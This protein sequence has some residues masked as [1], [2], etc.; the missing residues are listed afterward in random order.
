MP[1]QR[2]P[3]WTASAFGLTTICVCV[4]LAWNI[5]PEALSQTLSNT[6][7]DQV[8]AEELS[9]AIDVQ[10]QAAARLTR[11]ASFDESIRKLSEKAQKNDTVPVIVKVRAAFQPEG[12]LLDAAD[13]LAQRSL[14]AEAQDRLLAEMSY[15][16]SSLKK[17]TFLP[18][19]AMSVDSSGL[20]KLQSSTEALMVAGDPEMRLAAAESLPLVSALNAWAGGYTGLG[21]T[22]VV[23]DSGVDKNHSA[24][25]GKVVSE[26][27]F[28]TNDPAAGYSSLCPAGAES[29][30]DPGSGA[31]CTVLSGLGACSH[32]THTA[33]IAA[34]R[35]GVAKDA[36][37]ISI[38]VMSL[39]TDPEACRG[40][41]SCLLSRT[42]DVILALN[43]VYALRTSHEIAAVNI[44]LAIDGY[45][46]PC[47]LEFQP[48]KDAIDLLRTVNIATVIPSGN[49]F[50]KDALGY[51]ACI[52]SAV[53]VGAT[54]D[55]SGST[56]VDGV[57]EFSN[58]ASFLSLLAPG[59]AITSAVPGGVATGAG[60]SMAAAH[61]TGAWALLKQQ[62]AGATVDQVLTSLQ[63]HGV[64][65]TDPQ[66]S[67]T[68]RRI[69]IDAAM[70]INIPPSSWI[71]AYYNNRDLA[72]NPVVVRDDGG[73][74][75]DRNF[76]GISP[77]P[78]DRS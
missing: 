51:P 19:V 33:G 34:G 13:L 54:G 39:V 63:T 36:N 65:I 16:P 66:N 8:S 29:S 11:S 9:A 6:A 20:E 55:G 28:S 44:S 23:L 17:S 53:S 46:S 1:K 30:L 47:D 25:S 74:F 18:Y 68:K 24:L 22:V 26:A 2:I 60:T 57:A 50:F 21:K 71:G 5:F 31:H 48:L 35:S 67:V 38:Q 73:G 41:A 59:D 64:D 77:A 32:G 72:G 15:V 12:L 75:I 78:W 49:E 45:T 3:M 56:A 10:R 27:C 4:L 7:Q 76:S 58:S 14:I 40:Q 70:G 37:L 61:V 42:S 43:R 62:N 52:S 69:K